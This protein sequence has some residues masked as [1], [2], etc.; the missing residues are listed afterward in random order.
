MNQ[1]HSGSHPNSVGEER[2]HVR[3]SVS[4]IGSQRQLGVRCD[5]GTAEGRL[6]EGRCSPY[7]PDKQLGA[8]RA[9]EPATKDEGVAKVQIYWPRTR[10][11]P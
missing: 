2:A 7:V 3:L 8:A 1:N 4:A 5:N 11:D 9:F 10:V 6:D